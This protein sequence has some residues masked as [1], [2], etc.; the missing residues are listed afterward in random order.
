[1]MIIIFFFFF[2]TFLN[3]NFVSWASYHCHVPD[4][5]T[6]AKLLFVWGSLITVS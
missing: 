4:F 1:M 6:T 5:D 3:L 2:K